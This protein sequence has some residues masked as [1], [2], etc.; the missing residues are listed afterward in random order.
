[1]EII[2]IIAPHPQPL[3]FFYFLKPL[4]ILFDEIIFFI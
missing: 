4:V 2:K 1:M 3:A